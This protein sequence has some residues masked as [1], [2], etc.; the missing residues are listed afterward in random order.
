MTQKLGVDVKATFDGSD[1]LSNV[2]RL[3]AALENLGK[4]VEGIKITPIDPAAF[5]DVAK[6][7]AEL[8]KVQSSAQQVLKVLSS[9]VKKRI[10]E[11]GQSGAKDVFQ[12]DWN[13]IFLDAGVRG[14][15]LK[16]YLQHIFQGTELSPATFS[17][18]GGTPKLS[19]PKTRPLPAQPEVVSMVGRTLEAGLNAAGPV[20]SAVV[21]SIRKARAASSEGGIGVGLGAGLGSF[22]GS[23]AALGVGKLVGGI[24]EHVDR[25]GQQ[26]VTLDTLKRQLGDVGVSF[27]ELRTRVAIAAEQSGVSLDEAAKAASNFA[28]DAGLAAKSQAELSKAIPTIVGFARSFGLDVGQSGALFGAARRYGVSSGA[29][30]DRRLALMIGEAVGH[31]GGAAR[32]DEL[33]AAVTSFMATQARMSLSAANMGGLSRVVVGPDG[34]RTAGPGRGR[35]R[36]A[37][38]ASEQRG[39]ARWH[40]GQHVAEF[41]PLCTFPAWAP[42]PFRDAGPDGAGRVRAPA[43]RLRAGF[44]VPGF[45]S[46][47]R[48]AQSWRWR[49][50]RQPPGRNGAA[51]A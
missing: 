46:Q 12:I 23:L 41:Q 14:R 24:R 27:D 33:V 17:T 25:A 7:Q 34:V 5:S 19:S 37:P 3:N 22:V 47:V 50:K 20:G 6:L 15:Q 10:A 40:G 8:S 28:R 42:E 2:N 18:P 11:T 1:V 26:A 31:S 48:A 16:S 39:G 29:E 38:G 13:K 44:R 9:D 49:R 51:R 35:I 43:R 36:G 30:G 32:T 45:C 21:Q 4:H